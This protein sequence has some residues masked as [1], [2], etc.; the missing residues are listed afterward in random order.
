MTC[1]SRLKGLE[2]QRWPGLCNLFISFQGRLCELIHGGWAEE[3]GEGSK[4]MYRKQTKQTRL[5]SPLLRGGSR[6]GEDRGRGMKLWGLPGGDPGRRGASTE[7]SPSPFSSPT[8]VSAPGAPIMVSSHLWPFGRLLGK[9][10][11]G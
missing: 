2:T 3:A 11:D 4:H 6:G 7:A 9:G 10:G 8:L 1:F 5:G